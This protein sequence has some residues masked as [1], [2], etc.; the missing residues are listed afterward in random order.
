M[1]RY[2]KNGKRLGRPALEVKGTRSKET[3]AQLRRRLKKEEVPQAQLDLQ[4]EVDRLLRLTGELQQAN[5]ALR[6]AWEK[7]RSDHLV[8]EAK[9]RSADG[10]IKWYQRRSVAASRAWTINARKLSIAT[11]LAMITFDPEP[12]GYYDKEPPPMIPEDTRL[13]TGKRG[14]RVAVPANASAADWPD[15]ETKSA[16]E[17]G[18][19]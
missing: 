3:P 11:G 2:S 12:V 18:D 19:T 17:D 16:D 6:A 14:E 15:L 5:I 10:R 7:A 1:A 8:T 4:L 9:L 13:F